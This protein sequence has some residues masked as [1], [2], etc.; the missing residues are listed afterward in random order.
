[1]KQILRAFLFLLLFTATGNT[2]M[3]DEKANVTKQGTV[4]GRIIDATKQTL[5]GASIYIEKLHTGVTSDVNGFYTF[6]NLDPGTYTVKVSYVGYSPVELKITIPAGRTLEKDVVLNEGVELQ[7]VVV[8]GAFQGQRRAINSQ[9]NN[10]GITNVVSADQVG[11]FPD[12]NIGDA[13]KRISGINVQYDQGEARFGQVRGTSADLSSV[14]IN[15]NRVPSAEGD[16]RNV[17]LD[18]IPAD[19]IQTIEVNKVV[20]ADMDGD[21]IG[22]SINL[23]YKG[24]DLGCTFQ[25]VAKRDVWVGGDDRT[26]YSKGMIFWGINGGQWDSTGY[27]EHMDYF[28]PEGD[29]MG[30]NLNAYYPRPIIGSKQNQQVQSRYLQN[31]AYIRLKNIQIGYTLPKAWIQK[32]NLE[33]V[34]LFFSGDNLW[35]GT[36]MSKNFDPELIYQNGMSYPLSYTL[37]CGINITL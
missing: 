11:K 5:P 22:G 9:K 32:A 19:M 29:E 17:Q 26:A 33:K 1:M 16:T 13:L 31:A 18:L 37:S 8:G 21:A 2:A 20:T 28:R 7:E 3:A 15:G 12:S 6:S 27:E 14:T 24:F 10:M 23:A 25:G 35:T 4:R 36:K 30:A 34:R